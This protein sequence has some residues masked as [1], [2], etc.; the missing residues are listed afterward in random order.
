M[1]LCE[2]GFITT[3]DRYLYHHKRTKL[4]ANAMLNKSKHVN[5]LCGMV[6][7]LSIRENHYNSTLHKKRLKSIIYENSI[8]ESITPK[9]VCTVRGEA[10]SFQQFCHEIDRIFNNYFF[11]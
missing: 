2:C 6:V 3:T 9:E 4:H 7:K 5:C 10:V 8:V 11:L 1:S